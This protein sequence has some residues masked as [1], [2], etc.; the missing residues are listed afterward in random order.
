MPHEG[1]RAGIRRIILPRDNQKDLRELP[2]QVRD[3]IEFV[4]AERI[5]D[6][7]TAAIPGLGER[8]LN[9]SEGLAATKPSRI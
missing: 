9:A 4:P 7:L 8:L 3:E 1:D 5:E 6:A 2:K